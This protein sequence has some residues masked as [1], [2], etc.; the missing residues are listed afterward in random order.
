[1][2]S[3]EDVTS[4]RAVGAHVHFDAVWHRNPGY[5]YHRAPYDYPDF[6]SNALNADLFR[7]SLNL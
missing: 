6:T 3:A 7:D 4:Q 2:S 5:D 1:M